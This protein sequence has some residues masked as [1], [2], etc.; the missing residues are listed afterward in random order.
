MNPIDS[1]K[2]SVRWRSNGGEL[3][4][5]SLPAACFFDLEPESSS[6]ES[7]FDLVWMHNH[8]YEVLQADPATLSE[9]SLE[10][11]S[12]ATEERIHDTEQFWGNGVYRALLRRES[13]GSRPL[14]ALRILEIGTPEGTHLLRFTSES[15]NELALREH[16]LILPDERVCHLFP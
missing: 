6:F 4:E 3:R 5:K 11:W 16:D 13:V 8:A 2:I 10:V 15:G 14:S 9:T 7:I 12:P 1:I